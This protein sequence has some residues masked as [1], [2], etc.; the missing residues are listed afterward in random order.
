[1]VNKPRVWRSAAGLITLLLAAV[2]SVSAQVPASPVLTAIK[3]AGIVRIGVKTDVEP[4][5]LIN[6]SGEVVG[7]EIDLAKDIAER[8][9]VRLVKVPVSTETRFQKLE[10]GE[11]DLLLATVGD[12]LERRKIATG[13][14]PGYFET[15]VTVMLRPDQGLKDWNAVRGKTLCAL[16]GA[17]FNRPTSE[18]YL[19][20]LQTYK[21]VRDAL[22]AVNGGRCD[23][24][25]Y[26]APAIKNLLKKAEFKGYSAPFPEAL[27]T[28]WTMFIKRAEGGKEFEQFLGNVTADWYRN[29]MI[30][31]T[32][33]TWGVSSSSWPADEIELW[34][35]KESDGSFTCSRGSNGLWPAEC[36]R[37]EFVKS[38][39]ATGLR[40]L[41]LALKETTGADLSYVYDAYDRGQVVQ[42]LAYTMV[43]T[44][45]SIVATL[46][47]GV[48]AA[49]VSEA[50]IP[51]LSRVV[52]VL[53]SFGRL[54]PPLLMM[55]LLFFGVGG[56][57]MSQYAVKLPA[58]FVAVV[59][60]AYYSAAIVMNALHE[61]A[62][63]LRK[64]KPAFQL[65]WTSIAQAIDYARWPI[66]QALINVT[67]MSMI[68]SAIAI[69]E[70]LSQVNLIMAE[71]GNLVVMMCTL[72]V[73]YYL[74]TSFW[75][76]AFTFLESRFYPAVQKL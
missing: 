35:R 68:A 34:T 72:L 2:S 13:I 46:V 36:R 61:A 26:N 22:L 52:H 57:L 28:P 42:G 47:L 62:V 43:V 66:K 21:T 6:P 58:L 3:E 71:K 23:G 15:G 7:F 50:R 4:F 54:V 9:G 40:A 33:A 31:K 27:V 1:M 63:L 73:A 16:Q 39:D 17:Y 65:T 12:S 69:P 48:M 32:A 24:F 56:V 14:E 41:G 53:M 49:M 70:L 19:L 74:I 64:S 44:A 5:G 75:I 51:V 59:C 76:R 20:N 67:K 11:V 8:L 60:L 37:V 25:L 10:L 55:Y 45:L 30:T 38:D 29:G 18:R